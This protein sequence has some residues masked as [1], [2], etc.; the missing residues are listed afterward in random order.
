MQCYNFFNEEM[1]SITIENC[2][3]SIFMKLDSP[4]RRLHRTYKLDRLEFVIAGF[5]RMLHFQ[6]KILMEESQQLVK[7]S[8]IETTENE[9]S[10][11]LRYI[12]IGFE[13]SNKKFPSKLFLVKYPFKIK[14]EQC[15]A[16]KSSNMETQIRHFLYHVLDKR[17]SVFQLF[18]KN[19]QKKHSPFLKM[20]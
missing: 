7:I 1:C 6:P 16:S 19:P 20:T 15:Y 17:H 13:V 5:H 8:I 14:C 11:K 18:L 2:P 3:K 12:L 9:F 10:C 4:N